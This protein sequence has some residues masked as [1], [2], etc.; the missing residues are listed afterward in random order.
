M[1]ESVKDHRL[2]LEGEDLALDVL[3]NGTGEDNLLE[4]FAFVD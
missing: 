4:V 2:V 3:L 1:D